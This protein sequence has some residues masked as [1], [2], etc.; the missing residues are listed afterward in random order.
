MDEQLKQLLENLQLKFD[1]Q[2]SELEKLTTNYM[3]VKNAHDDL[4]TKIGQ[5]ADETKFTDQIN[6][7]KNELSDISTKF[8]KALS[9]PIVDEGAEKSAIKTI[10]V[11]SIGS[12]IS[13]AKSNSNADFI[14]HVKSF[15]E[16]Q[17][18]A[19]NLTNAADGGLAV[20]E[21][22]F[23]DVIEYA[24]EF[25]PIVSLVKFMPAMTR[26][27][28]EMVLVSYPS[29]QAGIE[30]VAGVTIAETATPTY[31]EVRSKDF[32]INA[33]PRITDEAMYGADIDIYGKLVALLG[34]QLGI[35]LANQ[36]LYGNGADKNARGILSSNRVDITD[37]TGE[38]WK[39]TLHATPASARNADFFP[40]IG[41]GVSG[42]LGADFEAVCD[43]VV[44]VCNM[45]PTMYLP[46][47]E[48]VMN[49]KTKG[50][51]EKVRN[52]DGDPIFR[53][54][55]RNG[56]AVLMLNGYPVRIDDTYP[57]VAADSTF[58]T[59]GRMDLAFAINNGDIDKMLLDPYSVD[60]CTVIKT[61][62]EY[63]EMIQN[64]DA[65]II[66]AATANSGA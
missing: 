21:V 63:F 19:A 11:K 32:K 34:V 31:K 28:R 25:S 6:E 10:V 4:V 18:K 51:F 13:G 16:G 52:N 55:Y 49:R 15:G 53:T 35:S 36:I 7:L 44:D 12:W 33:K 22:L 29:T 48:W 46:G 64:S 40:A 14:E 27:F 61:D 57:D 45:L 62:K 5:G 20:A 47:A 3:N 1:A 42:S 50:L 39:P 37:V 26:N 17:F 43:F 65:I 54:D 2:K 66:C 23:R 9:N 30:N 8:N 60:G 41:T 56:V 38:S 58:A 24:R 59:F